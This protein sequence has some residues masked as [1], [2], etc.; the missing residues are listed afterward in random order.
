MGQHST[1][2]EVGDVPRAQPTYTTGAAA[3]IMGLSQQSVIR[4]F[5]NGQ[6]KGFRVPGSKFRRIP[7]PALLA[8]MLA[9][10]IPHDAL[11]PTPE[12]LAAA[13]GAEVVQARVKLTTADRLAGLM[14]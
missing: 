4:L 9:S 5:D 13:G 14:E 3:K 2:I 12:E 8:F 11:A 7:R 1:A 6:L 10:G